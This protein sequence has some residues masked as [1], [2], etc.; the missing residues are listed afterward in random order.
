MLPFRSMLPYR[1]NSTNLEMEMQNKNFAK[2]YSICTHFS[3]ANSGRS[4]VIANHLGVLVGQNRCRFLEI[5]E[6]N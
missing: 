2:N 3:V 1:N 5:T 6:H 4:S